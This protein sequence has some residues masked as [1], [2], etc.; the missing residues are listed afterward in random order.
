M[1]ASPQSFFV[2]DGNDKDGY[3]LKNYDSDYTFETLLNEK[4]GK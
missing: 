1:N 2:Y 4:Y 3:I